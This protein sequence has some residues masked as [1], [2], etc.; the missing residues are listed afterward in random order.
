M[1]NKPKTNLSFTSIVVS[2]GAFKTLSSIGCLKCLEEYGIMQ[3]IRTCV[4]TSAGSIISLAIVLGF[5]SNEIRDFI[6]AYLQKDDISSFNVEEVFNIFTT[7][8]LNTG[9]NLEAFISAMIYHK[10]QVKDIT[11]LELAK[12][13][14][15]N[16][17]ICVANISKEHEEFWC[18]DTM[19]LLNVVKAVRASCSLPILFTPISHN[20]CMYVD[21]GIYNNFPIDY[22]KGNML[23]DIVGINIIGKVDISTETFIQYMTSLFH[24]IIKRL[25]KDYK[26]AMRQSIVT[27]EFEDEMWISLADFKVHLPT[28]TLDNYVNVGYFKMKE[29][30]EGE[31][32][33][34]LESSS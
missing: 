17:V 33:S 18:I 23:R 14:G 13:T 24:T 7:Y 10:L 3:N 34:M 15:K 4:G 27:L 6:L 26:S 21:G 1:D 30:I 32:T 2:G 12:V 29:I 28:E 31:S 5:T 16:L 19:P 8:G 22:F 20:G 11:F 25:T 9:A